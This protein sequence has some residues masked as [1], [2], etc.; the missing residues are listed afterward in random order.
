VPPTPSAREQLRAWIA[1]GTQSIG[2]G[3]ST[4]YLMRQRLV[5][6]G[7]WMTMAAFFQD[8]T[9][10]RL[11]P[12]MSMIALAAL[13]GRRMGGLRGA[14]ISVGGMLIPAGIITALLTAGYGLIRDQPVV[15][16]AL[17]GMGSV[18]IGLT[19]GVNSNLAR[20]AVRSGRR[21]LIDLALSAVAVVVGL[22]E[23]GSP[24]PVIL[25]SLVIGGIL[26]RYEVPRREPQAAAAAGSGEVE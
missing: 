21:G 19:I 23:P 13:L 6:G 26:L 3:S 1:I 16:S 10:S 22:L 18:T 14:A 8:W 5:D 9:I 20:T 17:L 7:R 2:G 25:G 15:Q 12:G 11:T 24:L 4:L